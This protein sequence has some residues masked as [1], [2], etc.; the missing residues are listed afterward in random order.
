M[1]TVCITIP[2]QGQV[3]PKLGITAQHKRVVEL[4]D[5]LDK[6]GYGIVYLTARSMAQDEDTKSYLFQ[7]LQN[8]DGYSLPPGPVL[9]SPVTFISGLIAEVVTK[10]PDVQKSKNMGNHL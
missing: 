1:R 9:F 4:F 10:T 8:L 3:L 7:M 5:K 2:A 6:K